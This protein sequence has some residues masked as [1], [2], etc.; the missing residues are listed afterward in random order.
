MAAG[1]R[2]N[3]AKKDVNRG[4]I[5]QL[6]KQHQ[7]GRFGQGDVAGPSP[8]ARR[9]IKNDRSGYDSDLEK[10]LRGAFGNTIA[11]EYRNRPRPANPVLNPVHKPSGNRPPTTGRPEKGIIR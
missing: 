11:D 4:I 8:A 6:D 1:D 3:V 7:S 10:G 2:P 9:F 5:S